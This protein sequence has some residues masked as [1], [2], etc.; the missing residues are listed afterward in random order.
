MTKFEAM[1]ATCRNGW[2]LWCASHDWN[3]GPSARAWYDDMTG[4][5]VTYCEE[6]S[7]GFV[8]QITEA[9]HGSPAELKAW[10]GY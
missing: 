7:D 3:N 6:T 4:E 1:G 5:L 2:L 9:R 8:W 10:A